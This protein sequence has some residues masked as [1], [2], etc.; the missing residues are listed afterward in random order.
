MKAYSILKFNNDYCWKEY[1]HPYCNT[2]ANNIGDIP[3]K[4]YS[5]IVKKNKKDLIKNLGKFELYHPLGTPIYFSIDR[6]ELER[7]FPGDFFYIVEFDI[8]FKEIE[9]W[10]N[11]SLDYEIGHFSLGTKSVKYRLVRKLKNKIKY[12]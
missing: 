4:I 2:H 3:E 12:Y 5:S 1:L 7:F 8:S 6:I 9:K 11:H 10:L